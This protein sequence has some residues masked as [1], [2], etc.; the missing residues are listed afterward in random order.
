MT[1]ISQPMTF[2]ATWR[3]LA[4]TALVTLASSVSFEARAQ[5]GT[6]LSQCPAR[7]PLLRIATVSGDEAYSSHPAED[8]FSSTHYAR[9]A[10]MP[11][12]GVDPLE[13][14]MDASYGV[15]ESWDYLPGATGMKLKIR[16]GLTFNDGAPV[17]VDDVAFSIE[18]T[19]SKFADSQISGTLRGIGVKAKVLDDSTV[20]IDFARGSPTF[21][22]EMSPMVFPIYVTSKAYHS[23]GE[24]SQEAFDKFRTTP[25]AAGP[26]RVVARQTQQFITLEAARK[27]PLL[28]CPLFDRI[29]IRNV[30]ETGT[31]MNQLRTGQQD[32]ITGS[33]EMVDQAKRAGATVASRPDANVIGFY[34]FHTDRPDNVF[35][36][37]EVRQA[38]AYAIDHKLLAETIWGGV[39]NEPW[40]C[41]WPP[42]TEISTQNPRYVKACSTPYPYDP[43]KAKALLAEAGYPPGKGPTIT[44]EYSMSY[45]EEAAMAEAME[46]MLK[47]VGFDAKIER[48]DLA[49]RNR[50][51]HSGGHV[52]SL[53][54]FGPGG[55][56]TALAGV[57]S[58]YGPEQ[59]WGPKHDK[60]VVAAI[61]RASQATSLDEYTD[62]MGEIGELVHDRAYGPGFFSAGAI[63]FLRKGIA[64]WGLNKSIGRAPMN[65]SAFVTKR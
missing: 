16:K 50:R 27:D 52:N 18:A 45:P 31:R 25:L 12:F 61:A 8:R 40:G 2:E 32:I 57:H 55:R 65:L 9:L 36:K 29:E 34:V 47:A 26:Y 38:A 3:L 30:A 53:L 15:A 11:L 24:I 4:C 6:E 56:I 33:R 49:E 35:H 41:T 64:D 44:L 39:G 28:G 42:P 10:N 60:D 19:A 46:P 21:H 1:S 23:N 5:S 51:R 7:Q 37:M 13:S 17:T 63:I 22:L 48:T 20:Q 14:K 59:G 58:V 62:A 54:F 43:A